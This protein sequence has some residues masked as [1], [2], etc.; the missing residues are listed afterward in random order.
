MTYTAF[1]AGERLGDSYLVRRE[2]GTR[3]SYRIYEGDDLLLGRRVALKVG[4]TDRAEALVREG[5]ALA[6][7]R[8][9]GLPA[10][11]GMG[12]HRGFTYLACELLEGTSVVELMAQRRNAPYWFHVAEVVGVLTPLAET[13]AAI[14][15]AGR[16]HGDV[17]GSKVMVCEGDRVVLL[18]YGVADVGSAADDARAFGELAFALFIGGKPVAGDDIA[19]LR[20]DVLPSLADVVHACMAKDAVQRPGMEVVV[21]ELRA[22]PRRRSRRKTSTGPFAKVAGIGR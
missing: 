5:K 9:T 21:E 3:G 10:V 4:E 18:E 17:R 11:F 6:A 13:L 1:E 16:A 22:I 20:P 19:A 14:H 8:H 12:T 7:V 15:A 2:L